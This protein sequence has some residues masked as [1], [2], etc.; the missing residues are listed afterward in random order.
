[1]AHTS[2]KL[3]TSDDNQAIRRSY[4]DLDAT[5]TV[6]GWLAAQVGNSVTQAITT[7]S[8]AGDT[9]VFT[10]AEFSNTLYQITIVYTDASQSTMISATRTA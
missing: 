10:F 4:N 1:M 7:T 3:A 6:N 5:L 8:V 9:S 2:K